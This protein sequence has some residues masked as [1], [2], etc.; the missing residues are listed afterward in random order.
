MNC[1][2]G[3]SY[4]NK[5]YAES[6]VLLSV[7]KRHFLHP[8]RFFRTPPKLV[9]PTF[10]N[11]LCSSTF[12]NSHPSNYKDGEF[13]F[14]Q[15]PSREKEFLRTQSTL[16]SREIDHP[17]FGNGTPVKNG[18]NIY[19]YKSEISINDKLFIFI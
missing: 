17:R 2:H 8:R 19:E 13:N 10:G 12:N 11:L 3:P 7:L 5:S 6:F 18:E 16:S 1:L 15:L 14:F 4:D 9:V